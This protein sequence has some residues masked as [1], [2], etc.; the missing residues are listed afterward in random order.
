[1][2][3]FTARDIDS[4]TTFRVS[5]RPDA[6]VAIEEDEDNSRAVIH[7]NGGKVYTTDTATY[8]DILNTLVG[9]VDLD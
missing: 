3:T 1:M 7:I 6:I 5:I 4:D 8:Q 9:G 2:I